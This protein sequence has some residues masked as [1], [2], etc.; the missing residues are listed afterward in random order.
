[1]P[2][3][4]ENFGFWFQGDGFPRNYIKP[5]KCHAC[6]ATTNR[7]AKYPNAIPAVPSKG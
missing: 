5:S 6:F 1:M 7:G 3:S 2:E 4:L